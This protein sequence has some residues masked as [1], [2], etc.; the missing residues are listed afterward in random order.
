MH[1]VL[2]TPVCTATRRAVT[3]TAAVAQPTPASTDSVSVSSCSWSVQKFGGSSLGDNQRITKAADFVLANVAVGGKNFVVLSAVAAMTDRLVAVVDGTTFRSPGEHY[4][5][6]LDEVVNIHRELAGQMLENGD[7][8]AYMATLKAKLRGIRDLLK[9]TWIARSGSVC[10]RDFA[11]GY[12]DLWTAR[13]LQML[14]MEEFGLACSLMEARDVLISKPSEVFAQCKIFK[15]KESFSLFEAGL[16]AIQQLLSLRL[17][18][19]AWTEKQKL[20]VTV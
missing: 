11:P 5:E 18:I 8:E 12:G 15:L 16:R 2:P 19:V 1:Y 14:L 7:R 13:L 3:P 17:G 10:I 4:S 9:R 6:T 20:I